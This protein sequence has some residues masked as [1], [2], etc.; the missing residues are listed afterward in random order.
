MHAIQDPY[1]YI[2]VDND[3]K[4]RYTGIGP[5]FVTIFFFSFEV[6]FLRVRLI[7][8]TYYPLQ[9]SIHIIFG[10]YQYTNVVTNQILC[11]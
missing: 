5:P 4:H 3:R 8:L 2:Y 9:F 1:I 10:Y 6:F 11:G 7:T